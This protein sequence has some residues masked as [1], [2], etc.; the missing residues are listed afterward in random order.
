MITLFA[1]GPAFGLPDPSPFVMKTEV[2]LKMAGVPYKWE[3]RGPQAAPKGKIP[4]I[5]DGGVLIGDSTFI[6][7][8]IERS[9]RV[10][11]DDGLCSVERSLAWT[12]ERMLED[13]LYFALL[14]ARWMD[15]ANGAKGPIHFFDG[16]PEGVANEARERVRVVL[17]GQGLGRHSEAEITDLATRS[18]DSLSV[19]LGDKPYLM[20]E[21]PCGADATAL[22]M[23][24]GILTPFFE[25]PLRDA[26]LQHKNLVAYVARMLERYYPEFA[27]KAA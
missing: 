8:H 21:K 26:A 20:G 23:L 27:R 7:D 14:H 3:R 18:L 6:R 17:H 22:G 19:F 1:F 2:Q 25:T 11:L 12:I 9:Y 4:F 15:D 24:A 5:E 13:Q 16:A 10:D